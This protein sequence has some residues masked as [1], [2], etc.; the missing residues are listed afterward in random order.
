MKKV[1]EFILLQ[2]L[3][4]NQIE[5]NSEANHEDADRLEK[6]GDSLTAEEI[7]MLV[8]YS[9]KEL[10]LAILI[11]A[12]NK[13]YKYVLIEPKLQ[14]YYK[15]IGCSYIE[16]A[17]PFKSRNHIYLDEEGFLKP[18]PYIVYYKGLGALAGNAIVL[19]SNDEGDDLSTTLTLDDIRNQVMFLNN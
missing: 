1:I 16:A 5:N 18:N 14:S 13:S 15:L 6:L 2:N 12:V 17:Y 10:V 4:N 3:V 8:K 9:N 11:D 19:S 7:D